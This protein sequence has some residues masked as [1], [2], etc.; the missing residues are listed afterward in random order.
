ILVVVAASMMLSLGLSAVA[1]A[2][3]TSTQ[4]KYLRIVAMAALAAFLMWVTAMSMFM[5]TALVS[6][7]GELSDPQFRLALVAMFTIGLVFLSLPLAQACSRLA[8]PAESRSTP[9]RSRTYSV[10]VCALGGATYMMSPCP[11]REATLAVSIFSVICLAVGAMSF[12]T[13]PER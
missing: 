3:S 11:G 2:I 1:I 4:S 7:P 6:S 8:H 13:E 12:L 9:L 10:L 5:A